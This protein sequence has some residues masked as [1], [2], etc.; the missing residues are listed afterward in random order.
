VRKVITESLVINILNP[1]LSIFFFAFLPQ[2]VPAS[3]PDA[4]PRM[5]ELSAVFMGMTFV[6]FALYGLFAAAIR[7][8]CDQ[9]AGHNGLDA[10]HLCRRLRA[11]GRQAGAD[12]AVIRRC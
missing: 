1:K 7:G 3:A 5:L 8:P 6:V 4:V 10:P 2:F 11:A 9:P 12:G